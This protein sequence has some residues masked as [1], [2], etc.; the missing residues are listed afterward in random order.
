MLNNGT[1]AEW[2]GSGLQN[3]VRRFESARYLEKI[4]VVYD[5]IHSRD[6]SLIRIG[7]VR[8]E[9]VSYSECSSPAQTRMASDKIPHWS[10]VE[11]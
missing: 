1:L 2:L 9:D 11:A 10:C 5:E 4:P 6:F 8:L 3:R 7:T